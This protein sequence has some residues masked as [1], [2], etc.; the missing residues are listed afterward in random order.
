MKNKNNIY[1]LQQMVRKSD[2]IMDA[3]VNLTMQISTQP[4]LYKRLDDMSLFASRNSDID[5]KE[6]GEYRN[7]LIEELKESAEKSLRIK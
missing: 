3:I 1:I 6:A 4:S 5:K 2:Q 7:L